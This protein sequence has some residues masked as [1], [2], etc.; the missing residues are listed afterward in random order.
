MNDWAYGLMMDSISASARL[1]FTALKLKAFKLWQTVEMTFAERP[2]VTR[3][4]LFNKLINMIP[5]TVRGDRN[6]IEKFLSIKE[7]LAKLG[8]EPPGYTFFDILHMKISK[9]WRE[10]LSKGLTPL[11]LMRMPRC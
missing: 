11:S 9:Q 5:S 4:Q 10:F 3:K 1:H 7:Q 2:F 8:Y 6:Y